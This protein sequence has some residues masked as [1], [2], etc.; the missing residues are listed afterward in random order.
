MNQ[1]INIIGLAIVASKYTIL[2]LLAGLAIATGMN[3]AD[4][5]LVMGLEN[6]D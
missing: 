6:N 5:V 2:L 3:T 1:V 4:P